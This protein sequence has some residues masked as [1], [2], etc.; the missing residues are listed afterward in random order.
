MI[1]VFSQHERKTS[2][3]KLWPEIQGLAE[4]LAEELTSL[5]RDFHQHPELSHEE[6][7]TA[8]VVAAYL[9]NLGLEVET[10]IAG[11]GVV[12]SLKGA[13]PGKVVAFR[14][15]MDALPLEE[16][17]DVPWRSQE[18]GVMH[19][20]GHD[21]H[22]SIG[23]AAAHLLFGLKDRLAGTYKFIFQPAEEGPPRWAFERGPRHGG[24]RSPG[25]T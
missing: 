19:A 12:G 11:H 6:E 1:I 15:D 10:G 2:L 3:T 22:V 5:R 23:L 17:V 21:F 9:R 25:K 18:D 13:R 16:K 7:R 20:C 8:R 24:R 14:A 4:D